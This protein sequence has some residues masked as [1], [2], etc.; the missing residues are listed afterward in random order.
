MCAIFELSQTISN[1]EQRVTL[2]DRRN[3]VLLHT[4]VKLTPKQIRKYTG[5]CK[6]ARYRL[7]DGQYDLLGITLLA[8]VKRH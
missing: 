4:K 6:A 7:S 3:M 1:N 5:S 8:M 2:Q